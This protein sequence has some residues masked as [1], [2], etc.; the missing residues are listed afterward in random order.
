MNLIINFICAFFATVG[1]AIFFNAPKKS[2]IVTGFIGAIAWESYL[3]FNIYLNN[4]LVGAFIGSF[5]VGI[6]GEFFA[7]KEK[8]PATIFIAPGIITLV[9]GAGIYNTMLSLVNEDYSDFLEK[10]KMT[11]FIAASIAF[12]IVLAGSIAKTIKSKHVHKQ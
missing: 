12:G 7:I 9:P 6:L 5:T 4:P 11:F 10:G 1:F 8:M 3:V 2:L